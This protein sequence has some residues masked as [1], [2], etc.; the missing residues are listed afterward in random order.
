MP[1]IAPNSGKFFPP[2]A[3]LI[4][5]SVFTQQV[6]IW[7]YLKNIIKK[8]SEKVGKNLYFGLE[9]RKF[10][11]LIQ[12]TVNKINNYFP[13]KGNIGGEEKPTLF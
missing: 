10:I 7:T 1:K 11:I 8:W 5:W 12:R 6:R 13:L 9:V 2:N 3:V 4:K